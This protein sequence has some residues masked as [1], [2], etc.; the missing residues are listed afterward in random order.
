MGDD[1]LHLVVSTVYADVR[2]YKVTSDNL[3]CL[4]LNRGDLETSPFAIHRLLVRLPANSFGVF[5]TS[6]QVAYLRSEK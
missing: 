1:N 5:F 4:L 3:M 2:G 6:M